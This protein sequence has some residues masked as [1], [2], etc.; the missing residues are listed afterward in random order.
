MLDHVLAFLLLVIL[1]ARALWRDWKARARQQSKTSA[2]LATIVTVSGLLA[3]LAAAWLPA[4]RPLAGLGL[5][6]PV[7]APALIALAISV[8]LLAIFVL[9][10]KRRKPGPQSAGNNGAGRILL[11]DT[12]HEA[13]LFL[14]FALAVGFGWEVLYRGFLLSYLQPHVGLAGAVIVAAVAYGLAHGFK[15]WRQLAASIVAS[16]AFT[17]G[18]VLTGNLWWLIAVHVS[19]PLLGMLASRAMSGPGGG[20]EGAAAATSTR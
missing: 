11:P 13:R 12:P 2:Y 18:Y 16:L 15:G 5:A 8:S 6:I 1:P 14:L 20:D 19:L 9:V 4:G 10:M 3:L 17:V 7:E